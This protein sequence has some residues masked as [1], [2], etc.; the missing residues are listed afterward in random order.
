MAKSLDLRA[1]IAATVLTPPETKAT[2]ELVFMC[3][4]IAL[5]QI[6]RKGQHGRIIERLISLPPEDL[7]I[8]CV[9]ELF[10]REE[11]GSLV[12]VRAYFEGMDWRCM[13]N[14]ELMSYLRR[15]VFAKVNH[16]IFR[17]YNEA[18]P[19]LGKIL[20]NIKIAIRSLDHFIEIDR[21][22]EHCICPV[23]CDTL[24]HL[25][26]AGHNEL[27]LLLRSGPSGNHSVPNLLARLSKAL[28]EQHEH[29]RV[30]CLITVAQVIRSMYESGRQLQEISE[31][32]VYGNLVAQDVETF[33]AQASREVSLQVSRSYI[34]KDESGRELLD[35]Y[36]E[37]A[38]GYVRAQL[39]KD[40]L[41]DGSL[42]ERLAVILPGLS[43]EQY[44]KLHKSKLE[45]VARLVQQRVI[46]T[47]KKEM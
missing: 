34:K 7:A 16:G 35:C 36:L 31:P 38:A 21:F 33:I 11:D 20:R 43:K 3:E 15:L 42:Y 22:G 44:K 4:K 17:L 8:D 27:E 40:G 12:Q 6:R 29:S 28:R 25:P 19:A 1:I 45:Y 32:D 2:M 18:D 24:E 14:E 39:N 41:D 10:Q 30:V 37:A 26:S 13:A 9:A 47:I 23:M 5:V 46:A